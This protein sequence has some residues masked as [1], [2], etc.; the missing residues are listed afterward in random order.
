[1]IVSIHQPAYLPW[2]GYFDKIR[3]ADRF[4]Y[5]DTVQFQKSSFQNRNKIRTA[6]GWTWLTIPVETKGRL[7]D[8]PLRDTLINNRIDWRRKHRA[9]IEMNYRRA[10][11]FAQV[12]PRLS[13]FYDRDWTYLSALC[14]EMLRTF[15]TWLS[16]PTEIVA[17]S[18]MPAIEGTKSDLVLNLCLAAGA[19]TYLSGSQG[20]DY[21]ELDKFKAAGIVVE[22]QDY[23]HPTYT[24]TYPGFEPNMGLVDLLMCT[25]NPAAR[26]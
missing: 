5:L 11:H 15:S 2:L 10:P 13:G 18:E 7:F 23:Q 26:I 8:T 6:D 21:L 25:E 22:F 19:T 14:L 12:F 16:I 20:R 1:M 17:A 3:R 9:A 4:I 24:Q